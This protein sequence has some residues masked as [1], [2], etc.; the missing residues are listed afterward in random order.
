MPDAWREMR[1]KVVR[2][3]LQPQPGVSAVTPA[4][5]TGPAR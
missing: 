5:K 4:E 3:A 2:L 1:V